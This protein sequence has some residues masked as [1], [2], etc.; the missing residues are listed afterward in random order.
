MTLCIDHEP[1]KG[2]PWTANW[3]GTLSKKKENVGNFKLSR[4]VRFANRPTE[5]A[6]VNCGIT[7]LRQ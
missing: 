7:Q 3:G 4:L 6:S 5:L 2:T 1:V